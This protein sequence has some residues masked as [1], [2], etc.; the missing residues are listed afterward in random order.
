MFFANSADVDRR[1]KPLGKSHALF[2]TL[3]RDMLGKVN[4]TG[5]PFFHINERQQIGENFG[6]RF[7][8]AL[9]FV[10]EQGFEN[11]IAMGND[12]PH[13]TSQ[14]LLE[15]YK[16]LGEGKTVIGPSNDGG[17]YLLGLPK[18]QF[19]QAQFLALPWQHFT[20]FQK[21][22]T[23]LEPNGTLYMLPTFSD[24]DDR[25]DIDV[26]LQEQ[27]TISPLIYRILK[28]LASRVTISPL[29]ITTTTASGFLSSLH[30]KGSPGL[31]FV[32]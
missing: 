30:N 14:H 5:I 10:Y 7:T 24:I 26:L 11:V 25:N 20:L 29:S 2:Q 12:T 4:K 18:T 9:K 22:T 17:F 27:N 13:L 32:I 8:A 23:V 3:S 19:D 6:S 15:A 1:R 21:I 16:H 31:R 28:H